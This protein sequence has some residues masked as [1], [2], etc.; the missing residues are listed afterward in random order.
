MDITPL[1][2]EAIEQGFIR[3]EKN[4]KQAICTVLKVESLED[5]SKEIQ[6]ALEHIINSLSNETK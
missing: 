4:I 5:S 1:V 2:F 3:R 6:Q